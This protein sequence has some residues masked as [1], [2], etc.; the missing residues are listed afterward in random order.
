[1]QIQFYS[2]EEI[3]EIDDIKKCLRN[4]FSIPEGSLQSIPLEAIRA[5]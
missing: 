2:D 4:L 1:M 3:N 5:R